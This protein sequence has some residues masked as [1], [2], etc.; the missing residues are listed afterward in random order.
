MSIA[1]NT[2]SQS[3][4]QRDTRDDVGSVS[5]YIS[6]ES[7]RALAVP[8][9]DDAPYVIAHG[10]A[11]EDA[12]TG[13][14]A[15]NNGAMQRIAVDRLG[16]IWTSLVYDGSPASPAN[17]IAVDLRGRV[18]DTPQGLS[19]ALPVGVPTPAAFDNNGRQITLSANYAVYNEYLGPIPLPGDN[20]WYPSGIVPFQHASWRSLRLLVNIEAVAAGSIVGI[21]PFFAFRNPP[22]PI[23]APD[24]YTIGQGIT[25]VTNQAL[26]PGTFPGGFNQTI[27]P[28]WYR[29]IA[30]RVSYFSVATAAPGDTIRVAL[31]AIDIRGVRAFFLLYSRRSA[32]G[33]PINLRITYSLST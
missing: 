3:R 20:N 30:Q 7:E 11:S 13:L 32:G 19:P 21:I 22:P 14:E 17:P 15:E 31:P 4:T 16:R 1:R 2:H 33:S 10:R 18:A 23:N 6:E 28:A 12:I 24:W 26:T 27:T 9:D 25:P 5:A 8:G 29:E